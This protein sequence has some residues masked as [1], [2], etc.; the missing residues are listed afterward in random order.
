[1]LANN[2]DL[3]CVQEVPIPGTAQTLFW[4]PQ[5]AEAATSPLF[6]GFPHGPL[7]L[8]EGE[9]PNEEVSDPLWRFRG[10]E[11]EDSPRPRISN[12]EILVKVL[13]VGVN[14]RLENQSR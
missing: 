10:N 13:A 6:P 11:L 2:D 7:L 3:G 14:R 12:D 1:M 8:K 4:N 9:Y 5:P